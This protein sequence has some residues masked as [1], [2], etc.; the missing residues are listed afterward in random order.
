MSANSSIMLEIRYTPEMGRG[1]YAVS[2]I[3]AHTVVGEYHA[4]RL[5]SAEAAAIRGGT[6]SRFWFE[7]VDGSA[8]VVFGLIELVN[9]SLTPNCDRS[10][11]QG[12]GGEIVRLYAIRDIE[13]GEQLFIDYKFDG[14]ASDPAWSRGG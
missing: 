4:L 1:V 14:S 11:H 8:S 9:H 6:L 2:A 12:P 5:P 13:A 3:A 10:W 7:D